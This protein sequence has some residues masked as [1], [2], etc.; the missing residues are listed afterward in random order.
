MLSTFELTVRAGSRVYC[1]AVILFLPEQIIPIPV[2]FSDC[3]EEDESLQ[4]LFSC[5]LFNIH[6]KL[7]GESSINMGSV[8]CVHKFILF[9]SFSPSQQRSLHPMFGGCLCNI[10][11]L[12]LFSEAVSPSTVPSTILDVNEQG[13][14]WRIFLD[15]QVL[16]KV[17][18]QVFVW[19]PILDI[20]HIFT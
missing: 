17:K 4:A 8:I 15:S 6:M 16:L 10:L 5:S 7:L 3:G 11:S 1:V 14:N 19:G 13:L 2:T 9:F 12:L 18:M 20:E